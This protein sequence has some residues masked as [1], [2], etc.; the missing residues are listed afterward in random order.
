MSELADL[1]KVVV[2]ALLVKSRSPVAHEYALNP[3]RQ[4]HIGQ[5]QSVMQG[6]LSGAVRLP[7]HKATKL[8]EHNAF[9]ERVA[10]RPALNLI[11]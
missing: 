1:A 9:N 3:L 5:F 8:P 11:D 6:R 7:F 4:P 10:H 2:L